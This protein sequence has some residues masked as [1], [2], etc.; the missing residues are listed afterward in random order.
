MF[1]NIYPEISPTAGAASDG[2]ILGSVS[3]SLL[4]CAF[5]TRIECPAPLVYRI[6]RSSGG[7][8]I[9]NDTT[10]A[11]S[12]TTNAW[13]PFGDST[14]FSDGDEF[15]VACDEE[16]QAILFN[17]NT[18]ATHSATLKVFDSTDGVWATN[19]LTVTDDGDAFRT[20]GWHFITLP[21]NANRVAWRPSYDPQQGITA[22]KFYR[23]RLE[24][25]V[26]GNTPPQCSKI[27]LVR[28]TF[29]YSEHTADLNAA[30]N[31]APSA[32]LHHLWPESLWQ[33]CFTN[34][35]YGA[36]VY[37]HLVH[38]DV[39]TDTHEY[40]ASDATWKPLAGWSNATNDFTTGP[41]VLGDPVQKL[42][43]RWI[44]PSDWAAMAQV[45]TLDDGSTTTR[46]G[47]WIR[48]RTLTVTN[49]GQHAGARFVVRARQFGNANSTGIEMR[50]N[51]TLRG[52]ALT[53]A[54]T[55]NTALT[56][57]QVVNMTTGAS[58]SFDI[59]ANTPVPANFDTADL[60]VN[61]GE[62]VG[63]ICTAGGTLQNA[64]LTLVS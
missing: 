60:T 47:H 1:S 5:D 52:V 8:S 40:L 63:V 26:G 12:G 11:T 57:L 49:Y 2:V 44:I 9:V 10:V 30:T 13:K 31:I 28:K 24:G 21:N 4:S 16:I 42:P 6:D 14:V 48:E 36:E 61:S 59:P 23:F 53:N 29:R 64:Q 45:I 18:A 7:M 51:T 41:A 62:R 38:T 39:I 43:I 37:M 32:N 55:V 25:I 19:E 3:E 50:Q 34:P 22:K 58:A 15:I 54:T 17:V 27:V 35:A 46:T 56:T 33:W 20:T